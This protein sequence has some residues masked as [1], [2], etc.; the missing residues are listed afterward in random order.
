[1]SYLSAV[2]LRIRTAGVIWAQVDVVLSPLSRGTESDVEWWSNEIISTSVRS[3]AYAS[4]V[5]LAGR[6]KRKR[7]SVACSTVSGRE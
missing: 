7:I 2:N 6:T 4:G 1:M 3:V 5:A